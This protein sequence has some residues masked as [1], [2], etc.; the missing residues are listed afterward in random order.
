MDENKDVLKEDTPEDE[1]KEE[2]EEESEEEEVEEED[3]I[4][5]ID[6]L[7]LNKPYYFQSL[8]EKYD[9][10]LIL[11]EDTPQYNAYSRTCR[12]DTRRQPVIITDK[13]LEKINQDHPGFLRPE[14]V[15]K[16]GSNPK[17]QFNYICP[18]YWCLKTNTI[19]DPSELK[20][21]IGD[22]GK[23]ELVH[24]TCGKVLDAKDKYV[25]PGHYIYEFYSSKKRYPGFQTGKHPDGYCLPCCFDKYN[26][27]GR[28]AAMKECSQE[29]VK[30]DEL[31]NKINANVFQDEDN[32]LREALD[33]PTK[34]KQK[35]DKEDEYIMG[36]EKFP[37]D[38][39]RWGYIQPELEIFLKQNNNDCQISKKNTNIK[40]NVPCLLRHGI[41]NNKKQ[42]FLACIADLLY[43]GKDNSKNNIDYIR[44]KIIEN[45]SIDNFI[46]YQ[47]GNLVS[48]FKDYNRKISDE[49]MNKYKNSQLY[50]KSKSD[51]EIFY[52]KTVIGSY[53]NFINYLNDTESIIDYTYLWD[54]VTMR[55]KNLF[56][57]GI[58]LIIFKLPRDDITNNVQIICPSNH[59]SNENY[60]AR[61]PTVFIVKEGEYFEPIYTYKLTENK[62]I[63]E[64]EFKEYDP[65]LSINIRTILKETIKPIINQLCKPLISIPTMKFKQAVL[66]FYIIDKLIT[67]K[68]T[69]IQFV[70]NFN[71][72]IIGIRASSPKNPNLIGFIPCFPSMMNNLLQDNNSY[73]Y[74]TDKSIWNTYDDTVEFLIELYNRSK[75]RKSHADIPCKPELKV[76]EDNLIV[77]ILTETNQ[78]IQISQPISEMEIDKRFDL[79]SFRDSNYIADQA[80]SPM[81][82]VDT[83]ITTS[84]QGD[85]E[86]KEYINKIKLETNFFDVFRNTIR[87]LL[88]DYNNITFKEK[89]EDTLNNEFLIYTT[90]LEEISQMLKDLVGDNI[91]FIGDENYYKL[92]KDTA[93]CLIKNKED[94]EED[95]NICGYSRDDNCNLILPIKNLLTKKD[96]KDVYFKKIADE[97]IRYS[98]V[99][100]FMLKPQVF[101]SFGNIQYNLNDN[102]I[103]LLQS[104]LTQDYFEGLIPTISSKFI[105]YNSY[106][107]VEPIQTQYYNNSYKFSGLNMDVKCLMPYE[108]IKSSKWNKCFPSSFME[109]PYETEIACTYQ[110]VID[111]VSKSVNKEISINEIKSELTNEYK[112]LLEKTNNKTL[113][114]ILAIEGKKILGDQLLSQKITIDDF[115]YN[116][117]YFLT[118]MDIWIILEKYSISAAFISTTNILQT[119]YENNIF[120]TRPNKDKDMDKIIFI[121]IPGLKHEKIPNYKVV[122]NTEKDMQ[123][124]I[125]QLKQECILKIRE[126]EKSAKSIESF[127]NQ[128]QKPK[129]KKKV[130][131]IDESEEIEV[132]ATKPTKL[133]KKKISIDLDNNVDTIEIKPKK[134]PKTNKNK[135]KKI[136]KESIIH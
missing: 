112:L 27:E 97:I 12:S 9:P 74:M 103:I 6:G 40:L 114:D 130:L 73:V 26:T 49:E 47:N 69:I 28:I 17:K 91:Q 88:N 123:I 89:L 87:I 59:Y 20:E 110:I 93:T 1:I 5:N 63:I 124:G 54:I 109:M 108:S 22:D 134:T 44:R 90:K 94:C 42:S 67:Y 81:T 132:I 24:P 39:G 34:T 19:I 122:V 128:F 60:E 101:L 21:E 121:I 107:E 76:I 38:T 32:K 70:M 82:N 11:K 75:K 129:Q 50:Q 46:I 102:E 71:N 57:N 13:Q 18:R 111:I 66:P 86:R 8:I 115:I 117:N 4:K 113:I 135:T 95:G 79:P 116:S 51:E 106:D 10:V 119:N 118:P 84:M 99:K 2:V 133:L 125:S 23:K 83:I 43:Y 78:F 104:L 68:Y 37:L 55:N 45:I 85:E 3:E 105:K 120:L 53:E 56:P 7:K 36:P 58:N 62:F 100:Q 16:Y 31:R 77:G 98:R 15:I 14:D 127:I 96:N 126:A 61:K 92:I 64:K 65:H 136:L 35:A 52:F 33:K 131:K 41:I 80:T 30:K 25:K 29:S 48:D 72:K